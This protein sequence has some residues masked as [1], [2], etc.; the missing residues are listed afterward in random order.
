MDLGLSGKAA[1]VT[2]SSRGLGR[3]IAAALYAEGC[4]VMLN[5]R[6][7]GALERQARELG[8][9]AVCA[10]A[11]VTDPAA[12]RELA[13]KTE[14]RF[15]RLDIL[16]CN[17]GSGASVPPGRETPDEW[18]RVFDLNLASATNAVE[19]ASELMARQGGAIVCVSSICGLEALG[20]PVTYSAAKAALNAYVRGIARPLAARGVRINAVAPG[21]LLFEGSVWE[22]KLSENAGAVQAMLDREVALKRLGSPEEI[23]NFVTFLASPRAAFAT[24]AVFVVD[25][26]QL[27]S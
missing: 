8:A 2:G 4:H 12:C 17:V 3:A 9:N 19:A 7:R 22:R 26:G 6:D 21:N 15:G 27:R 16:V 13:R 23:S 18:R 11:D 20:A 24:G 25:G 5:G 14:E 10:V 1:L